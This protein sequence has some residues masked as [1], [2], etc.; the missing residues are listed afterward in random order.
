VTTYPT[1]TVAGRRAARRHRDG[2]IALSAPAAALVLAQLGAT[3]LGAL[4]YALLARS[5]TRPEFDDFAFCILLVVPSLASLADFGIF[6]AAARLLAVAKDRDEERSLAG[7]LFVATLALCPIFGAVVA[8]AAVAA[9]ALGIESGRDAL[10][11]AAPFAALIPLQQFA[12][13][14]SLATNRVG[15]LALQRLAV[16]VVT[17]SACGA[18]VLLGVASV[19]SVTVAAVVGIVAPAIAVTAIALRPSF[20]GLAASI[21]RIAAATRE[22]GLEIYTGRVVGVAALRLNAVLV[23]SLA[24]VANLGL[25][26]SAQKLATP[27]SSLARA[28]TSTRFRDFANRPRL[29]AS[30]LAW[31]AA[32]V[33]AAVALFAIAGP[34]IYLLLYGDAFEAG[35]LFVWPFAAAALFEGLMQPLNLFLA[36][37]GCGRELRRIAVATS[38]VNAV[39]LFTIVPTFG[40]VGAAWWA[41]GAALMNLALHITAY[42]EFAYIDEPSG[43]RYPAAGASPEDEECNQV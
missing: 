1:A 18:A 15:A 32:I 43:S 41:A 30:G 11:F 36:A 13:T 7:A 35:R 16:P 10:F 38:A 27:L 22:F 9:G 37:H 14:C 26:A 29:G 28:A 24:G 33:A 42:R 20:S 12:E 2:A 6:A 17:L 39:G 21:A 4:V 34:E 31:Y 8:A 25:F 23:P 19:R 40:L 5:L 3:A